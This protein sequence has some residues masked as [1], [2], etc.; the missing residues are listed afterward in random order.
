MHPWMCP[1]IEIRQS[2]LSVEKFLAVLSKGLPIDK[3]ETQWP[4]NENSALK[5]TSHA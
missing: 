2:D 5:D 1:G 3:F 4:G